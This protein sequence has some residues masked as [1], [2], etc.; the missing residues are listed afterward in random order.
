M[1]KVFEYI[2]AH[3]DDWINTV[4]RLVN[5]KSIS[6][7]NE[8]VEDCADLLLQIL[9]GAGIQSKIIQ[10]FGPPLVYGEVKSKKT[11]CTMHSNLWAL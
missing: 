11:K 2:D 10:G 9:N 8:G 1:E 3:K 5:Q 7:L 6:C 4:I